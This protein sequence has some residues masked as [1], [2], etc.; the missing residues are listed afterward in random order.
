MSDILEEMRIEVAKVVKEET[1][2]QVKTEC[3][4]RWLQKGL[5]IE[6]IA[7]GENMSVE[8]VESIAALQSM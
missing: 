4:L 7:Y 3:V 2:R 8:Q 5:S 1:T 6:D